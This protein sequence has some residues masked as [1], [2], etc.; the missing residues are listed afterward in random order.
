[1]A[2]ARPAFDAVAHTPVHD[3]LIS[4]ATDVALLRSVRTPAL[5]IDSEGSSD[6]LGGGTAAVA[7]ALPNGSRRSLAG[8]WHGVADEELAP[9]IAEYLGR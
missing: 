8:G 4:D 6:D 7:A 3:C 5:V 9:V 2:P 1:M